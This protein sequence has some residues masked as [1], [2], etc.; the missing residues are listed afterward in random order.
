MRNVSVSRRR[1]VKLLALSGVAGLLAACGQQQAPNVAPVATKPATSAPAPAAA[2]PTSSGAQKHLVLMYVRP[3]LPE[4]WQ[5]TYE[6]TNNVKIDFENLDFS[7]F[8]AQTAAGHPPDSVRVQAPDI[9]GFALRGLLKDLT[10]YYQ[11]STLTKLDDLAPSNKYFQFSGTSFG[12]GKYYGEVMDWSPDLSLFAN[13]KLFEKA[14]VPL[15][16]GEKPMSYQ[17]VFGLAAKL[18]QK[19]NGRTTVMGFGYSPGW[20]DR[21]IEVQL[22]ELGKTL[23]STDYTKILLQDSD[24]QKCFKFFFDFDKA[25]TTYNVLNPTTT[26]IQDA[27]RKGQLAIIQAGYYYSAQAETPDTKGD[28]VMLPSLTWGSKHLDP[29][30][31]AT[32]T[33]VSAKTKIPDDIWKFLEWLH[34]SDPAIERAKNGWGVPGLKSLY[35][36]MPTE[37][38]FQKQVQ[39]VLQIELKISDTTVRYNPYIDQ[40]EQVTLNPVL[41]SYYKYEESALRGQMTLDEIFPKLQSDVD[42]AIQHGMSVIK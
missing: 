8:I 1:A 34:G 11:Q 17:D 30:V 40:T 16:S 7:T 4:K 2:Q 6:K 31:S 3:Q 26:T 23:W 15:P 10:P 32:G 28:V 21:I 38:D 29:C 13:K 35:K 18:T 27:F 33:V 12:A 19:A 39:K 5:Q 37:T 36:Y 24:A 25:N 20:L 42:S 22:N 9:P 41:S 14:G